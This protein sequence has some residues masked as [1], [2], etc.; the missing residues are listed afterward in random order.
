MP[1]EERIETWIGEKELRAMGVSMI[2]L[3]YYIELGSRSRAASSPQKVPYLELLVNPLLIQAVNADSND[4]Q[5]AAL[6][7][8]I[9]DS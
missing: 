2:V 8:N 7:A 9:I 3:E 6:I 1:L 5:I 4:K